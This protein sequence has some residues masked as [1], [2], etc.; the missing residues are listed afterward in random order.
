MEVRYALSETMKDVES[1]TFLLFL[2][3]TYINIFIKSVPRQALPLSSLLVRT[4]LFE[5]PLFSIDSKFLA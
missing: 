4:I 1:F 5:Y 3:H 2:F